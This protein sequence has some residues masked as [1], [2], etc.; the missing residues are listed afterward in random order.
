MKNSSRYIIFISILIITL[1]LCSVSQ[2]NA[3]FGLFGLGPYGMYGGLYGLGPF[4]NY[5][6]LIST[7]NMITNIGINSLMMPYGYGTTSATTMF[8]HL[9]TTDLN[10][11]NLTNLSFGGPGLALSSL[12]GEQ[13][14][15]DLGYATLP[16]GGFGYGALGILNPLLGS[17]GFYGG[18]YGVGYGLYGGF[19]GGGL[20]LLSSLYGIN[21]GSTQTT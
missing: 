5:G 8:P 13:Y 14:G 17:L 16:Y 1:C 18:L 15:I 21:L 7:P 4:G 3:Y 19:Y 9:S 20:G 6:G 12:M 10:L 11:L 2:T